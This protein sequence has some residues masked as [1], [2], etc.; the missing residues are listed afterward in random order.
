MIRWLKNRIFN[1]ITRAVVSLSRQEGGKLIY[2]VKGLAGEIRS[3]VEHRCQYGFRSRP[4]VGAA[5]VLF[6]LAGNK[7]NSTLLVVDDK[8]YGKDID[9]KEGDVLIYH[10][11]GTFS[12][13][14]GSNLLEFVPEDYSLEAGNINQT[15]NNIQSMSVGTTSIVINGSSIVFTVGDLIL[16][17]TTTG[18]SSNKD[19]I[20]EGI[21][22]KSHTHSGVITGTE[23]T[24]PPV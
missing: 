22:L 21:S 9:L 4:E 14:S 19:I 8:R 20:A 12:H 7:E 11:E 5:G 10:K 6:S 18:I 1:M 3:E 2:Q 16:T 15:A 13:Y 17:M 24:G 23:D